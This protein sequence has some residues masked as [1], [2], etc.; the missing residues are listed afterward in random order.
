MPANPFDAIMSQFPVLLFTLMF[1]LLCGVGPL[2]FAAIAYYSSV[3][4][5]QTAAALTSARRLHITDLHSDSGL[6]TVHGTIAQVAKPPEYFDSVPLAYLRLKAEYYD[7]EENQWK[8][9]ADKVVHSPF[10]LRDDSGEVWVNPDHLDK[11]LLGEGFVPTTEQE[12]AS[13]FAT[14][15]KVGLM[16]GKLR[17]R[18]WALR[19]GEEVTVTGAVHAQENH[20]L[21]AKAEGTPLAITPAGAAPAALTAAKQTKTSANLALILGVVGGVI[22]C[23]SSLCLIINLGRALLS[24]S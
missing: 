15:I 4:R 20:K 9:Y 8:G 12:E 5:K 22:L 3:K 2:T 21:I 11:N 23:A 18:C 1:G 19:E 10:L 13:L 17:F 24:S 6:V 7:D 14:G 16:K